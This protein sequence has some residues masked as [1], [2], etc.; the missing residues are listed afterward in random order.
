MSNSVVTFFEKVGSWFKSLF[1]KAPAVE[2]QIS[3]VVSYVA[4]IAESILTLVDPPAALIAT[5][6]ITEVETGLAT[7]KA[8]TSGVSLT[9]T[10]LQTVDSVLNS[11]KTNISGLLDIA[12][13]KN[14]AKIADI[15]AAVTAIT[16]EVDAILTNLPAAA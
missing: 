3:A 14:S 1:K 15:T 7:L 9:G 12:E 13:I 11:I 2:Q 5:P 10:T 8:T 16:G 4:P 6:I